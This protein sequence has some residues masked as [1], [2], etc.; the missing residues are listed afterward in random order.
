MTS[1]RR[2]GRG[3]A[4]PYSTAGGG[5]ALE[6][7]YGG[8]LLAALLQEAPVTGLD[9]DVTPVEV[10]FQQ[11]AYAVDDL[12]VVGRSQA[13]ERRLL[14]AVR[15]NPVITGRNAKF[16]ELLSRFLHTLLEHRDKFVDGTWRLGLAVAGHH[17]AAQQVRELAHIA[18]GQP[19]NDDFRAAVAAPRA[20]SRPVGTRLSHL[21]AAVKA[22]VDEYGPDL[23]DDLTYPA[24]TW[25]LLCA[26][27]VIELRLE[28]D[29]P[30]DRTN[31]VAQLGRDVGDAAR[32]TD[33]LRQLNELASGYA[34]R[35]ARIRITQL[36]RDLASRF[37]IVLIDAV[38]PDGDFDEWWL[39]DRLT[40]LP[41]ACERRV[42]A[43]WADD[44]RTTR[45]LVAA[46]TSVEDQPSAVLGEWA[47]HRPEW[48]GQAVW[49]VLLA[50]GDL[51][52]SYGRQSLAAELYLQAVA[53]GANRREH[54]LAR[55]AL[56]FDETD[57]ATRRDETLTALGPSEDATD[58]YARVVVAALTG[59]TAAAA[60]G[61]AEWSPTEPTER[62]HKVVLQ[63]RVLQ[64]DDGSTGPSFLD[65]GLQILADSLRE[66]WTTGLAVVRARLL[67]LRVRRGES[68]SPDADLREAGELA[69]R[70]RNDRRSYC[71]NSAEAAS[72][73]CQA[74][75][76]AG[77]P[78][79]AVTIGTI[80]AEGAIESEA[81]SPL[82]CEHV[83]IAAIQIGDLDLARQTAA[84]VGNPS[85]RA[86]LEALLAEAEDRDPQS[87]WRQAIECAEDDEALMQGLV[88]LAEAGASDLPRLDEFAARHPEAA[89][90][91]R[92]MVELAAGQP[93]PAI[94]RLRDRRRT[95]VVA[96]ITLARAYHAA[97]R[98]EDE[99]QTLRDAADDFRDPS[100]RYQAAEILVRAGRPA[101]A[102]QELHALLVRTPTA[103]QQ[104]PHA[105][106]LAAELAFRD[107]R[108]DKVAELLDSA[109]QIDPDHDDTRWNLMRV[110]IRRGDPGRAWQVLAAAPRPLDPSDIADAR[111]WVQLNRRYGDLA[112]TVAGCLRLLRRFPNSE[113][114]NAFIIS[115]LMLPWAPHNELPTQLISEARIEVQRFFQRWPDSRHLSR[116]DAS[117]PERLLAQMAEMMRPTEEEQLLR[118]QLNHGLL[119]GKLPLSLLAAYAGRSY[120]EV[121]VRRGSGT[122]PARLPNPGEINACAEAARGSQDQDAAIDTSA[123]VVLQTLPA[124]ARRAATAVFS[125]LHTTDEA[126]LDA[127]AANDGL[128]LRSAD[129]WVYD[130][131]L[132][133][134]R[135]DVIPQDDADRLAA[136]AA[137]LVE[138]FQQISRHPRPPTEPSDTPD[139]PPLAAWESVV[140]LA[141]HRELILWSDDPLQRARARRFGLLATSTPAILEHLA[142]S[143]QISAR[144]Y[145][146]A[147]RSLVK[148]RVG[149]LHPVEQRLLELAEDEDWAPGCVAAAIAR[150]GAW[151]N[152]AQT[153]A[154][155]Q[156]LVTIIATRRP[157]T[158][159]RWLFGA[160]LGACA[161]QRT[162]TARSN[163]AARL[164]ALAIHSARASGQL[165]VDL[166]AATR[167]AIHN[168]DDPEQAPSPDPLPASAVLLRDVYTRVV[169]PAL[170]TRYV[171]ATFAS[172]TLADGQAVIRELLA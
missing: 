105:L 151:T 145:E 124:D 44:P 121:L 136:E 119:V 107:Q 162:P 97:G 148:A 24:L 96:A 172:L 28:G 41:P 154:I 91:I 104:R 152:A 32:A 15:R 18:R 156:K 126:M 128:G 86:R 158:L 163:A 142:D 49:Q 78:R 132:G 75:L 30:A 14:I 5:I 43:A 48:L 60:R 147:I 171:M 169:S 3:H 56:L 133:G 125:R 16:V 150:P 116:I 4:H 29:D 76:T 103:W 62:V 81:N 67:I 112:N 58:P 11:Q 161:T 122:L 9:A 149:D 17:S 84:R 59:K 137:A 70:A 131:Q 155:F 109:L 25:L 80:N 111:L 123:V 144:T 55:A 94:G 36:H 114:F 68:P 166:V 39:Q 159:P 139:V 164:L 82:V 20:I 69:L 165:V 35:R 26:L 153:A 100:M 168:A 108:Y 13:R 31:V 135:L 90:E 8:L 1:Q 129:T 22:A 50:A 21:D 47:R 93:G 23:D 40:R 141:K 138:A 106:R 57:H 130:E 64:R 88:G 101:E 87:A 85:A 134:V 74:A 12:V 89:E 118:A 38:T 117:E 6:H 113:E 54:W 34:V 46:L 52:A 27:R 10:R 45:Q 53:K 143:G 73:A 19:T 127:L 160:V 79:L 170:A 37:P 92:A 51:A 65:R 146:D 140:G 2:T 115:N 42:L 102:D 66:Q 63:L 120:A 33:L 99:V 71:G 157:E 77:D 72:L 167:N 110:L 98:I 83:A 7:A 61:L 95:S